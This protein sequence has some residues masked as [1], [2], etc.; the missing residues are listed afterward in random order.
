MYVFARIGPIGGGPIG[1]GGGSTPT[2]TA[3]AAT[4]LC[5]QNAFGLQ[6]IAQAYCAYSES[7]FSSNWQIWAPLAGLVVLTVFLIGALIY[8]LGIAMKN[9]TVRNY[10]VGEIYEAL[11]TLIFVAFFMVIVA[12]L[13]GIL[14][15]V[16]IGGINPFTYSLSYINQTLNASTSLINAFY[17]V[18]N[19][20]ALLSSIVL[21]MG[22]TSGQTQIPIWPTS[23]VNIFYTIPAEVMSSLTM[24]GMVLLYLEYFLILFAMYAAIP[25][26]FIPGILL[27]AFLPTRNLGGMFMGI[28]LGLYGVLPLMFA[29]AYFFTNTAVVQPLIAASQQVNQYSAISAGAISATSPLVTELSTVQNSMGTFWLSV[30]FFPILIL[31]VTYFAITTFAD[32]IGGFGGGHGTGMLMRI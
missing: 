8:V 1:T 28:A 7:A 21:Q 3:A 5:A 4:S 13:F 14:P 26:F 25:V 18:N 16:F 15:G 31:G 24:D 30:L 17:S 22:P 12:S 23:L 10:G 29:I 20:L 2:G 32:F 9:P 19:N 27:R 11:A 6:S